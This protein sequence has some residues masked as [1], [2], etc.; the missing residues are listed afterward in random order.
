MVYVH[1]LETVKLIN[2]GK[3]KRRVKKKSDINKSTVRS[4]YQKREHFKN[5]T[6][7]VLPEAANQALRRHSQLLLKIEKLLRRYLD[8]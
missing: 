5:L 3:T 4:I 8:W 7:V 1:K 6:T 2:G